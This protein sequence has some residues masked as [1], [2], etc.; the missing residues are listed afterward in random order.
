M[1]PQEVETFKFHAK[2]VPK[3]I[4]NPPKIP[5]RS[6]TPVTLEA[7]RPLQKHRSLDHVSLYLYIVLLII[8]IDITFNTF[9]FIIHLVLTDKQRFTDFL[10]LLLCIFLHLRSRHL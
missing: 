2:P 7:P 8:T 5:P 1:A 4:Y 3:S 6:T 9:L 10:K